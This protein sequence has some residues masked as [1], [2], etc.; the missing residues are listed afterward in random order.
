MMVYSIL[1]NGILNLP[2]FDRNDDNDQLSPDNDMQEH[3]K[4]LKA[5]EGLSPFPWLVVRRE[6][7]SVFCT[8]K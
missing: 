3:P 5:K 4:C 8:G 1:Y 2:I 7:G 6:N